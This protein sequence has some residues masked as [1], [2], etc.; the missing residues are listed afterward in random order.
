MKNKKIITIIL[1]TLVVI[2]SIATVF[3]FFFFR[4]NILMYEKINSV[5]YKD[6]DKLYFLIYD[7]TDSSMWDM[8]YESMKTYGEESGAFIMRADENLETA[9]TKEELLDMAIN[10]QVDGIILEGE[11]SQEITELI[12]TASKNGIPVITVHEDITDSMRKSYVGVNNYN[13]GTEYGK[14][15]VSAARDIMR[16]RIVEGG[17]ENIDTQ[18]N[19][20]VLFDKGSST[21][22]QNIIYNAISEVTDNDDSSGS[23]ISLSSYG[24]SGG[25]TLGIEE[26]IQGLFKNADM[27]PDIVVSFN[28]Q[29]TRS[30]YQAVID[31]N[32]VGEIYIVGYSDSDTILRGIERNAIYAT[33]SVDTDQAAK[34]AITALEEYYE[35]GRVSEYFGV[36]YTLINSYN[37]EDYLNKDDQ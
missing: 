18:I 22:Y 35:M 13:L 15:I 28:E 11:D 36:D 4:R 10:A 32:Q 37:I 2:L 1:G 20:C 31:K 23:R 5:D 26:S 16:K 21:N 6:Y 9:Y 25:D 24:V 12:A 17:G 30:V 3:G 19:V 27:S 8:I 14:I 34:Y 33:I 7:K 29:N